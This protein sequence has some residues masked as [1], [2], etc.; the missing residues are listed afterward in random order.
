MTQLTQMDLTASAALELLSKQSL[1]IL[2]AELNDEIEAIQ[3]VWDA[4]DLAYVEELHGAIRARTQIELIQ[5]ENF[6]WGHRPS[7]IEAPIEGYPNVSCFAYRAARSPVGLDQVNRKIITLSVEI[8]CRSEDSEEEVNARIART[9]DA[10]QSVLSRHPTLDGAVF[11]IGD[12]PDVTLSDLM[13]RTDQRSGGN[14]FYWQGA[15]LEYAVEK[16]VPFSM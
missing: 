12:E 11:Q 13:A 6:Y 15:R 3:A 7:L 4:R 14:R 9:A 1:S 2:Y 16:Y 10:V 8:M 5:P